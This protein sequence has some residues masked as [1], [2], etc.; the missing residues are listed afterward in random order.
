M[1]TQNMLEQSKALESARAKLYES[2]LKGEEA[3][4]LDCEMF[5]AVQRADPLSE[6][7]AWLR[8]AMESGT[9]ALLKNVDCLSDDVL[10]PLCSLLR[11]ILVSWLPVSFEW[12][13]E[14]VKVTPGFEVVATVGDKNR[15]NRFLSE[16]I[17]PDGL[18]RLFP[19]PNG[20]KIIY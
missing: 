20:N 9:T 12:S 2:P 3:R 14:T 13:G 15:N 10:A 4:C 6:L 17:V 19:H 7:V 11:K 18:A 16:A 5:A 1:I 8:P